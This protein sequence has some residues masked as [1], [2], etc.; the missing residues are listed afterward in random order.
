MKGRNVKQVL[1]GGGYCIRRGRVNGEVK[2]DEYGQ[3]TSYMC[4]QT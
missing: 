2:E 3:G 1:L 4:M